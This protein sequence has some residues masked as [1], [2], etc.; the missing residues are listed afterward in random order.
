MI[1]VPDAPINLAN[2]LGVTN[3]YTIGFTWDNGFSNGGSEVL[4]YRVSYDQS[5]GIWVVVK[6]VTTLLEYV[7]DMYLVEGRTYTFRVESRNALGYSI[8]SAELPILAA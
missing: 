5:N 3:R 7:T 1:I 6:E 8:Y 4:D 2:N